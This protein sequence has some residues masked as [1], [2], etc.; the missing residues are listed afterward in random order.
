MLIQFIPLLLTVMKYE[1]NFQ[2]KGLGKCVIQTN[3]P[4]KIFKKG[5]GRCRFHDSLD[6]NR[7]ITHNFN[8]RKYILKYHAHFSNLECRYKC[9]TNKACVAYDLSSLLNSHH[10]CR[11]HFKDTQSCE[12]KEYGVVNSSQSKCKES[13]ISYKGPEYLINIQDDNNNS[14]CY[15]KIPSI[16]YNFTNFNKTSFPIFSNDSSE[17]V[18]QCGSVPSYA[19]NLRKN[20]ICESLSFSKDEII[21]LTDFYK[22]ELQVTCPSIFQFLSTSTEADCHSFYDGKKEN[23][24]NSGRPIYGGQSALTY[25]F[26]TLVWLSKFHIW[27]TESNNGKWLNWGFRLMYSNF[28]DWVVVKEF[29]SINDVLEDNPNYLEDGQIEFEFAKVKTQ[30]ARVEFFRSKDYFIREVKVYGNIHET[31]NENVRGDGFPNSTC[32]KNN[33]IDYKISSQKTFSFLGYGSCVTSPI[34][35]GD[36]IWK[37]I[38]KGACVNTDMDSKQKWLNSRHTH[39][40]NLGNCLNLCASYPDCVTADLSTIDDLNSTSGLCSLRFTTR[41]ACKEVC[42]KDSELHDCEDGDGGFYCFNDNVYLGLEQQKTVIIGNNKGRCFAKSKLY[43]IETL[44]ANSLSSCKNITTIK[45]GI[46]F[47]F[48]QDVCEV[49]VPNRNMDGYEWTVSTQN[50]NELEI[51]NSQCYILTKSTSNAIYQP[52][53]ELTNGIRNEMIMDEELQSIV[54]K[55]WSITRTDLAAYMLIGAGQCAIDSSVTSL[56]TTTSLEYCKL[57]A[58]EKGAIGFDYT[59]PAPPPTPPT[60]PPPP[61][62]PNS[63]P[64]L[65]PPPDP[66]VVFDQFDVSSEWD[67]STPGVIQRTSGSNNWVHGAAHASIGFYGNQ[68]VSV[69]F[70]C[71]T[72]ITDSTLTHA[73]TQMLGFARSTYADDTQC[74]AVCFNQL[75]FTMYCYEAGTLYTLEAGQNLAVRESYTANTVLSFDL[76]ADGSVDYVKDGTIFRSLTASESGRS[77]SEL[78]YVAVSMPA[79]GWTFTDVEYV[80]YPTAVNRRRLSAVNE[81]RLSET[82]GNLC[83]V[84]FSPSYHITSLDPAGVSHAECYTKSVPPLPPP[85]PPNPPLPGFLQYTEFG[86]GKCSQYEANQT[87]YVQ[88]S[89]G[90]TKCLH[91]DDSEYAE[92]IYQGRLITKVVTVVNSKFHIDGIETPNLFLLEH[93]VYRF[94]VSDSSNTGHPL[95]FSTTIDGSHGGGSEYST[96]V[97]VLGTQGVSGSYVELSLT[98]STPNLYYYCTSHSG[99]GA[100]GLF[101]VL[102]KTSYTKTMTTYTGFRSDFTLNGLTDDL[103]TVCFD[104]CTN[105]AACVSL[106]YKYDANGGFCILYLDTPSNCALLQS[107]GTYVS[108][109][110]DCQASHANVAGPE[111]IFP[112]ND[113]LFQGCWVKN[114]QPS[115]YKEPRIIATIPVTGGQYECSLEAA[116]RNADGFNFRTA[117]EG[118]SPPPASDAP[119]VPPPQPP[120]LP[121]PPAFPPFTGCHIWHISGN[122]TGFFVNEP[123]QHFAI[124][125]SCMQ[126]QKYDVTRSQDTISSITYTK[127]TWSVGGYD[128]EAVDLYE[129]NSLNVYVNQGFTNNLIVDTPAASYS[130]GKRCLQGANPPQCTVTGRDIVQFSSPSKCYRALGTGSCTDTVDLAIDGHS[131]FPP[132]LASTDPYYNA[133]AVLE[134]MERCKLFLYPSS[135]TAVYLRVNDEKCGC[136]SSTCSSLSYSMDYVSFNVQGCSSMSVVPNA[137]PN[138]PPAPPTAP[139]PPPPITHMALG[140]K[141]SPVYGQCKVGACVDGIP[142]TTISGDYGPNQPFGPHGPQMVHPRAVSVTNDGVNLWVTDVCGI[143]HVDRA[144]GEVTTHIQNYHESS[145]LG[146]TDQ[147]TGTT[148]DTSDVHSQ[149]YPMWDYKH[150]ESP[151]NDLVLFLT[152]WHNHWT[153]DNSAQSSYHLSQPRNPNYPDTTTSMTHANVIYKFIPSTRTLTA[154]KYDINRD[155]ER[156]QMYDQDHIIVSSTAINGGSTYQIY[157]ININTGTTTQ[158]TKSDGSTA[159][160]SIFPDTNIQY[161]CI[162]TWKIENSVL[163]CGVMRD[164]YNMKI[165]EVDVTTWSATS[166]GWQPPNGVVMRD[167]TGFKWVSPFLY[168]AIGHGQ[169][170]YQPLLGRIDLSKT[171][172]EGNFYVFAY[173]LGQYC[174]GNRYTDHVKTTYYFDLRG[175]GERPSLNPVLSYHFYDANIYA[176]YPSVWGWSFYQDTIYLAIAEMRHIASIQASPPGT[177]SPPP[178]YPPP[179]A[180]TCYIPGEWGYCKN[181]V[182]LSTGSAKLTDTTHVHYNADPV[183]E[184]HNRC[185][186]EHSSVYVYITQG[187]NQCSCCRTHH[188]FEDSYVSFGHRMYYTQNC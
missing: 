110:F 120:Q 66:Y 14:T 172:A 32:Y 175:Y 182:Y 74:S 4:S 137:P 149:F 63:P 153:L 115:R 60:S 154:L 90:G 43:E 2:L 145:S 53:A 61:P 163:Y 139:P 34:R 92:G 157:K 11:L 111:F 103:E 36:W 173:N 25:T 155:T 12:K 176:S 97:T 99:M 59:Y 178:Y 69:S 71:P 114:F 1:T 52:D 177:P 9:I 76:H 85:P 136:A 135:V 121:S 167:L 150:I 40:E 166:T 98:S 54:A 133:D 81:R 143:R 77:A 16:K 107:T 159:D 70:K 179:P 35:A 160:Y 41:S 58:E 117:T 62:S 187:S 39:E 169:Q 125:S 142:A 46:A 26:P 72:T 65:A 28:T 168:F 73:Q 87:S 186:A 162:F 37:Y 23:G 56:H 138:P 170:A 106:T 101:S 127:Y 31:Q 109:E 108:S 105:I 100:T 22:S 158:F 181:W 68:A 49:Y 129:P 171:V 94:D 122:S 123:G 152:K 55:S 21:D 78:L 102:Q 75:L 112:D 45:N 48:R 183:I 113:S 89:Q 185:N 30:K 104:H 82:P 15:G 116:S 93:N 146:M 161:P 164:Y 126:R 8:H 134:C 95:R 29:K 10:E 188:T 44:H 91:Y 47:N 83:R 80:D 50:I 184:C 147:S 96:Q 27:D 128:Y 165:Y 124:S 140:S 7:T 20:G 84:H 88:L 151:N 174:T 180:S 13:S 19:F 33:F 148:M 132:R 3:I 6:T 64:P 17:K 5:I 144:T 131:S 51:M 118:P 67:T 79:A 141:M 130:I 42:A 38:G 86:V 24:Y 57:Y 18:H 156:F 119:I